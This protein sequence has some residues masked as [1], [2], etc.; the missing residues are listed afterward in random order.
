[1][2]DASSFGLEA[3]GKAGE[4]TVEVLS[5][6]ADV[7][8]LSVESPG[9]C[10]AFDLA[11]TGKVAELAGFLGSHAGRTEFAELAI[12]SFG[13]SAVS[14][15]KDDEFPDSFFMRAAGDGLL[16]EFTLV[17]E[18]ATDLGAAVAEAAA[19]FNAGA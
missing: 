18:A 13:V 11:D 8:L 7:W 12:G 5:R 17:G 16:V 9:W 2:K 15:V 3:L 1:M 4:F 6:S 10:F 14:V 19:E